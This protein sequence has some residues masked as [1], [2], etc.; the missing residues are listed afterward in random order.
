MDTIVSFYKFVPVSDPYALQADY[1]A[2]IQENCLHMKGSIL[3]AAEGING[4]LAAPREEIERFGAYLRADPRFSSIEFKESLYEDVTYRRMLVKVRKE[5]VTMGIPNIDSI[6]DT[7]AFLS[8]ETFLQWQRENRPMVVVD[9]RNDYEYNL[10]T[11]R[12]ALNPKTDSFREFPQWVE[13]NLAD[14]KDEPIITF[15]TGGIRCEKATAFMKKAG[16]T[17]VYQI[18]GGILRYFESTQAEPDNGWEGDCVVFDKRKAVDR[19]LQPSKKE[20]CFVC[21]GELTPETTAAVHY[22]A[23]KS[24]TICSHEMEIGAQKR[25]AEGRRKQQE[26]YLRNQRILAE[27]KARYSAAFVS[28]SLARA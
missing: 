13:E 20:I 19:Y 23:G 25:Q 11:F 12:G 6:G 15:C 28:S 3:L 1:K 2:F 9:T 8:A 17:N 18:D 24:C 16:F 21:L 14:K 26:N 27:E 4:G 10:G 5:I 22:E 7:A